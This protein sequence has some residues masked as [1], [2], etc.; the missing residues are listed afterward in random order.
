MSKEFYIFFPNRVFLL[1][2]KMTMEG[3]VENQIA[4][5][6]PN[7][8]N[9]GRILFSKKERLECTYRA[10]RGRK[11]STTKI[12]VPFGQKRRRSEQGG[13]RHAWSS[14]NWTRIKWRKKNLF[15]ILFLLLHINYFANNNWDKNCF[16]FFSYLLLACSSLRA[17]SRY[18]SEYC[19]REKSV[20]KDWIN[21]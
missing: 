12:K 9:F 7:K 5:C 14:S 17:L 10:R 8:F 21:K 11:S 15:Y 16:H 1:C 4:D 13:E 18:A 19:G 3:G 20:N 6:R 2:I